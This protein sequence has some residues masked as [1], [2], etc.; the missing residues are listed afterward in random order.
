MVLAPSPAL[1]S[2]RPAVRRA[3]FHLPGS[4]LPSLLGLGLGGRGA[5]RRW[6]CYPVTSSMTQHT[7]YSPQRF[8]SEKCLGVVGG[9]LL[10]SKDYC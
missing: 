1:V 7:E 10:P 5:G 3:G 6:E 8:T 2:S 9:V 4:P